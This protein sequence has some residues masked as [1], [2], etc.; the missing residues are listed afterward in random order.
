VLEG[1]YDV[2][3]TA[4]GVEETLRAMTGQPPAHGD[5]L[6]PKVQDAVRTVARTYLEHA[7]EVH[8]GRLV[9]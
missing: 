1:G 4:K 8:R 2:E 9:L 6:A 7:I 3:A 5:D